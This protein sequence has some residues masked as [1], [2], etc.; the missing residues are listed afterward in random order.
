MLYEVI[1]VTLFVEKL[2]RYRAVEQRVASEP[3]VDTLHPYD[4]L[5]SM[6]Y[7]GTDLDFGSSSAAGF[8]FYASVNF[9]DPLMM[10]QLIV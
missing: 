3:G 6:N 8:L 10:N 4:A 1:T 2:P 7:S 5:G 9:A